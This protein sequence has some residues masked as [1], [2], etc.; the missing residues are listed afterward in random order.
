[1]AGG[2]QCSSVHSRESEQCRRDWVSKNIPLAAAVHPRP[3]YCPMCMFRCVQSDAESALCMCGA[4][5]RRIDWRQTNLCYC[6]HTLCANTCKNPTVLR[7][8]ALSFPPGSLPTSRS[9]DC[10]LTWSAAT[11]RSKAEKSSLAV[12]AL[13]IQHNSETLVTLITTQPCW[14]L[15]AALPVLRYAR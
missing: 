11:S 8:H 3:C 5:H 10:L 13:H 9:C 7:A 2:G 12:A 1:M 14:P 15:L 4:M 6:I